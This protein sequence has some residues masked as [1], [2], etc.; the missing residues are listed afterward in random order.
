MLMGGQP[1][2]LFYR[3]VTQKLAH[4]DEVPAPLRAYTARHYPQ[5]L[6]Q[7]TDFNVPM[8]S[9]WDVFMRERKPAPPL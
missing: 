1:G 7:P 2:Q 3:G 6:I 5:F 9:S 4:I 8:E